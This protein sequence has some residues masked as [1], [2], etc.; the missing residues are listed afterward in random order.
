[1]KKFLSILLILCMVFMF[2]ACGGETN[3]GGEEGGGEAA[4]TTE[5]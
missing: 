4:E 5:G 1:M 2:A 3:E